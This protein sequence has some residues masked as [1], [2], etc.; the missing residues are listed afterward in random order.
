MSRETGKPIPD[1]WDEATDGY[2][3]YML[4]CPNSDM[5]RG[6]VTG[7]IYELTRGRD[8]DADTGTI[9]DV[10]AI[11]WEVYNSMSDCNDLTI[12]LRHLIAA[13][14]GENIDLT[15]PDVLTPDSVDYTRS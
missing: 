1:D 11:A 14:V 13:I 4:C 2:V 6:Y 5:W 15:D 7:A 10:Q 3:T 9:T 12:G 8:W